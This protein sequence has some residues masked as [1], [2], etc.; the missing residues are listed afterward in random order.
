MVAGDL[1][2]CKN[3]DFL[4]TNTSGCALEATH[5]TSMAT[6]HNRFP[7]LADVVHLFLVKLQ[8]WYRLERG[9]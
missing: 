9:I 6:G 5:F 3:F 7:V 1:L 4:K 2:A 8:K